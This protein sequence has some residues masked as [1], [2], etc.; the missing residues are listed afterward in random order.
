MQSASKIEI[1]FMIWK[2]FAVML[3]SLIGRLT[4]RGSGT[5]GGSLLMILVLDDQ[6]QQRGC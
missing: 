4:A 5:A 3:V 1:D 2:S 6:S